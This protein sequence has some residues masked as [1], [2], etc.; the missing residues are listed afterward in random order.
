MVTRWLRRLLPVACLVVPA[1]ALVAC[2]SDTGR[3]ALAIE[4]ARWAGDGTLVVTAE[5]AR[6]LEVEVGPDHG[7]SD[8]TEVTVW[9]HP[10]VGRCT[11][12]VAVTLPPDP[13]GRPPT[14]IVDGTTSMVVELP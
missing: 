2:G 8:L 1:S 10:E 3:T 7:G 13:A 9:G 4:R 5:C 12:E 14:K 11:P 6:D